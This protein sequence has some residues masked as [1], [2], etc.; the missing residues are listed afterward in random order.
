MS[1]QRLRCQDPAAHAR[2]SGQRSRVRRSSSWSVRT[3]LV[4][5]LKWQADDWRPYSLK[6]QTLMISIVRAGLACILAIGFVSIAAAQD[7]APAG[8]AQN[9]VD[10]AYAAYQNWRA[11][12][13]ESE[14]PHDWAWR[15]QMRQ[16]WQSAQA[17]DD[18]FLRELGER[19]A[20][21]QFARFA[22]PISPRSWAETL[23]AL[24]LDL[25]E[26]ETSALEDRVLDALVAI[27]ASNLAWLRAA[28]TERGSWWRI[29]EVGLASANNAWLIVQHAVDDLD[30]MADVLA[31]METLLPEG[32]VD[33]SSYALLY[34]RVQMQNGEPQRYGSQFQCREGC[35][36]VW[37]LEDP[38]A[39]D[40]LRAEVGLGPFA[41]YAVR[42]DAQDA[43]DWD[44]QED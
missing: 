32:E 43:C 23:N 39:L 19:T 13:F 20:R 5:T 6:G 38:D 8:A 12:T 29:S 10:A 11:A 44:A 30:W 7:G 2:V 18:P 26:D 14:T 31:E 4:D 36:Q 3:L 1:Y 37:T 24:D 34:D 27:D 15:E 28:Y 17:E 40:G 42:F 41:D 9:R 33:G 35:C 16:R 21:D 25:T 22:A